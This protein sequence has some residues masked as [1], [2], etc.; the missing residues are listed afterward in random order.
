MDKVSPEK[1][2][3]IMSRIKSKDTSPEMIVRRLIHAMGYRYRVHRNDLPGRPDI[4]FKRRG[5]IIFVHGCF[6][7]LHEGCSLNRRPKSRENYWNAK[8]ERNKERDKENKIRLEKS[9]WEVLVI[10]E[11]ETADLHELKIRIKSFLD[12]YV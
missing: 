8:L 2:S 5:K 4:V 11:C 9:G 10:W 6:W 3:Q 1:R 12:N 7:H